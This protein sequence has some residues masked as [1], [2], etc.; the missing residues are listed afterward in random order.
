[1]SG[2]RFKGITSIDDMLGW[3]SNSFN[4]FLKLD[5]SGI[6]EYTMEQ[7]KAKSATLGLTDELTTQAVA[8]AKDADF[9]A[10]ASSGK[11]TYGEAITNNLD[12]IDK[13][14]DA[15]EKSGKIPEQQAKVLSTLDKGS[16]EYNKY[17]KTIIN[18]TDDIANSIINVGSNVKTSSTSISTYFK[19]IAA[20]IK[21]MIPLL[22][23]AGALFAA[24]EGF[25]FL[26]DKYTLTFDTA[27]KHLDESSA[28]YEANYTELQS[29]NSELETTSARI[30]ELKG[31]GK[32][33]LTEEAELAKLERQNSLLETQ[34]KLKQSATDASK[35]QAASDAATSINFKSEKSIQTRTDKNGMDM[36]VAIDRKQYVR[37]QV[38]LMEEAQ[39]Q[40]DQ[41]TEKINSGD[42]SKKWEEQLKTASDNLNT[43]KENATNT[44]SDLNS[45][46]ENL[47]DESTGNVIKGYEGLVNEIDSLNN[48]VNNFDL[49]PDEQALAN[50]NNYFDGSIGKNKIKQDIEEIIKASSLTVNSFDDIAK[51]YDKILNLG[52]SDKNILTNLFGF[53]EQDIK[54]YGIQ[55]P[56]TIKNAIVDLQKEISL[57][58]NNGAD[59]SKIVFGNIDLNNRQRLEWTEKNLNKYKD[60]LMSWSDE[61]TAWKDIK[62]QYEKSFSTVDAGSANFD[63]VEIAFTPM[64]QTENGA[65]YLSKDT[66][67]KYINTLIS[68][69]TK[70][71][72]KWDSSELFALDS[73]G[74]TIDGK[75]INGLLADIGDTAIDT[76]KQMHY[77]GKDGSV[78]DAFK[79]IQKAAQESKLTTDS[80]N[81]V[82]Q[83]YGLNLEDI[84]V[85]NIEDL[86][87]YFNDITE[88][89]KRATNSVQDYAAS[90]SDVENATSSENQDKNWST[91][92]EAYKS[93]KELLKEGKTG[94]DDFQSVASFLNPKKVK[95]YADEG[96]KYTADAYQKAFEDIK[97]TAN[98]WFGEDETKSMENFVND[99][100]KKGL[101]DVKTDDMGLWDITTNFKTTAEA[102]NQFGISVEA[103][104]TMLSG[105][106]AYGYDFSKITFSTEGITEYE[107]ALNGI[108]SIYDSL[109]EGDAKDRL[110]KLINGYDKDGKHISGWDE[111]FEKYQDDLDSL[112]EPQIFRIK[113]EYELAPIQQKIDELQSTAN[114]GGDTQTWAELNASKRQYREKS[115]DRKGN[116]IEDVTEYQNVSNTITA[117]QDQMR[118]ATDEQKIQI[119]EQISNLYDLQNAISDAFADSG[120]SWK[121]FIK[122]DEYEDAIADMISSSDDAKQAIA[123][124]LGVDVEDIK[125]DVDADTSKAK[126]NID[127]V[128]SNNGE[129]IVMYVDASTE[130][131]QNQIDNLQEGQTLHFTAELDGEPKGIEAI[132]NLD[133]TITYTEVETGKEVELHKDGTVT[134]KVVGQEPPKPQNAD[135]HYQN[136]GQDDPLPRKGDLYYEKTGQDEPSDK[137]AGVWYKIKGVIGNI[138]NFISGG[139]SASGTAHAYGT[140]SDKGVSYATGSLYPIPKLSGRALAMGNLNDDSWL[141]DSWRTK[142][143]QVALTGEVGQELVVLFLRLLHGDM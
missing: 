97:K 117:L 58:Q 101:F 42:K 11:L 104:E 96:G 109:S 89:T 118:T 138:A 86:V 106:E 38:S 141:K 73:K 37:E 4:E 110:D 112:S 133:G 44:L 6:S 7:I 127:G 121:E 81:S 5:S 23:T 79:R 2:A 78:A 31:K 62:S 122:T 16:D 71:G 76:A 77:L 49:S 84:G 125:I 20:S 15:L 100:K 64:L 35:K 55:L 25:K 120:L 107:T 128:L 72:S 36:S 47:Y 92:S 102:A 91:I 111:E 28:S 30:T 26:D 142:N 90:V 69:A 108:K 131:I 48:L 52:D 61:N 136:T 132:K 21:P 39:R 53:S 3:Q 51:S 27:Q 70:D 29:I 50:L 124:L 130:Q 80:A 114:E 139:S 60:A 99:F 32:L 43:Y 46:A 135:M 113:F 137:T 65:E 83:S 59:L 74:I 54:E 13:I 17:I 33:T 68:E 88:A 67:Y 116:K 45:E 134:Y 22:A 140:L 14:A 19:G 24:Y 56:E 40:I 8:L 123:D 95:E 126:K 143:K 66:V 85:S 93:A 57:A 129:T 63:G 9:T 115:E 18:S 75:Q 41:A 12:D 94:T 119:Q 103:V 1:M 105:L 10:K 34:Q 87:S 82:L 98:R